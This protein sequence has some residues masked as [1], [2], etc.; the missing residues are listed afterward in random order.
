MTRPTMPLA[1]LS[2]KTLKRLLSPPAEQ[3]YIGWA[4]HLAPV[5]GAPEAFVDWR[6]IGSFCLTEVVA[7]ICITAT[8]SDSRSDLKHVSVTL[9]D[10]PEAPNRRLAPLGVGGHL[11]AHL[12]GS[13]LN[14]IEA[15]DTVSC[16]P[17]LVIATPEALLF[18]QGV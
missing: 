18:D 14:V 11:H 3:N 8:F 9:F 6:A 12:A 5:A 17:S 13:T 1:D 15:T 16:H 2:A 7:S 4:N 10:C